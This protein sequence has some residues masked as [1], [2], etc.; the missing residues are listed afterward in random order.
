MYEMFDNF[1]TYSVVSCRKQHLW[2]ILTLQ[3]YYRVI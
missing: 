1:L 2:E 3:K